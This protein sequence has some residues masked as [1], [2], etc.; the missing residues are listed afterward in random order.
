MET[1]LLRIRFPDPAPSN[2][3]A[4]VD[5]I[6]E[7]IFSATATTQTSTLIVASDG[8]DTF[9]VTGT[10]FTFVTIPFVG[11]LPNGGT[12][13]SMTVSRGGSPVL[14]VTGSLSMASVFAAAQAELLGTNR[15][16]LEQ[17]F[18][19]V[20]Y[21]YQG[22]GNADIFLP[23]TSGDG[24]LLDPRGNDLV[25]L[26]GG[27]DEF[28]AGSG[29]DTMRGEAGN[30]TL[31]GWSG[32][33][34]LFGDG[35]NDSLFGGSG[36]DRLNG[37]NGR[38]RLSGGDGSDRLDGGAGDD[39]LRGGAG[40]DLLTGGAGRDTFWFTRSAFAEGDRDRVTDFETGVDVVLLPGDLRFTG[41]G[42]RGEAGDVRFIV[43]NGNGELQID[44][45]GDRK[46]D[47]TVILVGVTE[48]SAD[49]IVFI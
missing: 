36:D 46:A 41:A 17:L 39:D 12:I 5:A 42:F 38:D 35:R 29:N 11:T 28:N 23:P 24:F 19:S 16:A 3:L 10:G 30:D 1:P 31:Y 14:E 26:G 27:K 4:F 25:R 2:P 48:F 9:T 32:D 40:N 43:S 13:E 33:D 49:D 45:D 15:G 18:G 34:R 20:A 22:K 21:D 6:S 44:L 37:G 7:L 47:A 8:I